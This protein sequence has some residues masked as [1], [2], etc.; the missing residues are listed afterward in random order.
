MARLPASRR[1][2]TV[3]TREVP[4]IATTLDT[5]ISTESRNPTVLTREVPTISPYSDLHL[6]CS[7]SQS[8]RTDQG[9]SDRSRWAT[10]PSC[11][12]TSSQSHRTDQGSSDPSK[13]SARKSPALKE[14]RNPTVLTREVPTLAKR[15]R[16][17]AIGYDVAIPPC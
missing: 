9:S 6:G 13:R 12:F 14:S 8:H 7:T 15:Y 10:P 4:T 17:E 16:I 11:E 2:P 3:L 5:V 1:N